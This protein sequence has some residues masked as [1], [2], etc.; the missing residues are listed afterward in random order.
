MYGLTKLLINDLCPCV[1]FLVVKNFC[2]ASYVEICLM[3]EVMSLIF[4]N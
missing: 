4:Q 1:F 2:L 3:L